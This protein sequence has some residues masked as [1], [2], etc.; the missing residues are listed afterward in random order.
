MSNHKN[1]HYGIRTGIISVLALCSSSQI[2]ALEA[3]DENDVQAPYVASSSDSQSNY[4]SSVKESTE[5]LSLTEI[6]EE[7]MLDNV[8]VKAK[9]RT[10]LTSGSPMQILG[11]ELLSNISSPSL[12]DAVKRF[13]GAMVKD[14]GGIGGLKTINVRSM[15]SEHTGVCYDGVAISN[16]Q[17]GQIDL[18]NFSLNNVSQLSLS[19]G[20]NDDIFQPAKVHAS[21]AVLFIETKRP[22]LSKEKPV[23]MSLSY[24]GGSYKLHNPSVLFAQRISQG[25]MYSVYAD[26][27][28]SDGEYPFTYKNGNTLVDGTRTNSDIESLKSEINLY[29]NIGKRQTLN[30]KVYALFSERG[31]PGGIIYDNPYSAERLGD[32]NYFVHLN[33]ENEITEKFSLRSAAKANYSWNKYTDVQVHSTTD[34]RFEQYEGYATLSALYSPWKALSFSV[35]QDIVY[36]YLESNIPDYVYP[37]RYTS[38]SAFSAKYSDKRLTITATLLNT[39]IKEKLKSSNQPDDRKRLSPSFSI[40]YK[41]FDV[42]NLRIRASYKDIFRVPTFNDMY[43]KVVGNT[44][45]KPETSKQVNAGITWIGQPFEFMEYLNFTADIYYNVVD[46]KIVAFPTSFI[47]KMM[48]VSKVKTRGA[49]FNVSTGINITKHINIGITGAYSYMDA[50]DKTDR[51]SDL[52][53]NQIPYTPLHSGNAMVVIE[54]PILNFGYSLVASSHRYSSNMNIAQNRI[55]GYY[56]HSLWIDRTINIGSHSLLLRADAI[57]LSDKNYEVI[58]FYPM[59]GRNYRFSITY[60]Y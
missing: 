47:W 14:Y 6:A 25:F 59:P 16:C 56:D 10:N 46:D 8:T 27:I 12:S 19:I 33:Y 2:Y 45:L 28:K 49:D 54:N 40:S 13:S 52:W 51:N 24:R 42:T 3:Y 26:Y 20:Q 44:S 58:R 15:G 22:E 57:N 36:N 60:K 4:S 35:S 29:G 21:A 30:A 23:Y 17:S 1:N 18:S 37:E 50:R 7:R 5:T 55:P 38:L 34:N 41:P 39:F 48:N 31:L 11:E 32:R 43:Y 53:D 9:K